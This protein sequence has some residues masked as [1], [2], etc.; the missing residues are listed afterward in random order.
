[1]NRIQKKKNSERRGL[2]KKM[3]TNI[4]KKLKSYSKLKL[5]DI[6]LES[7]KQLFN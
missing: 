2:H 4:K 3:P 6:L 7:Q 1:M 5:N